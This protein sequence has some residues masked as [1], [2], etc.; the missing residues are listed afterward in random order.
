M[1][2]PQDL[3]ALAFHAVNGD[4]GHGREQKLSGSILASE[5]AT[6]GRLFQGLNSFVQL[7]HGRLTVVGMAVFEVVADV[8]KV[9]CGG[10]GPAD[11]HL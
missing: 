9:C 1:V 5:A 7:T 11:T 4:I 10:G 3:K 2:N 8:L 6:E